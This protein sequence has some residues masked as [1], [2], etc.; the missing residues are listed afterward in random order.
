MKKTI[1]AVFIISVFV[2]FSCTMENS[3]GNDFSFTSIDDRNPVPFNDSV[4][5]IDLAKNMRIGWNL[6]NSLD[7]WTE[8]GLNSELA[9]N[10]TRTTKEIVELGKNKGYTTI[11]IP[12]TWANHIIDDS[13]TIDPKWMARVKEVVDWAY[14][15]GYYVILDEHHSTN[16][17]VQNP[18]PKCSGYMATTDENNIAE[19]K[20][21]LEGIWKQIASTFNNSY[22]ERLIFETIN[23]P[24][25]EFGNGA[26]KWDAVPGS[27]NECRKTF[28]VINEYNQLVLNT[29]RASGGNNAKRFVMVPGNGDKISALLSDVF[30]MPN[31]SAKDKLMVTVHDYTM[32]WSKD[33]ILPSYSNTE[34]NYFETEF[35]KLNDK[36]VAKGIPV[37]LGETGALQGGNLSLEERIKWISD[38]SRITSGYG[39]PLLYW[40]VYADEKWGELD[41]TNLTVRN[42][43]F[44]K[45][46][47][48][49]WKLP[50]ETTPTFV[51][52][53]GNWD[54]W[55]Q[56]SS[57][58]I[59]TNSNG[60]Y[61]LTYSGTDYFGIT[62]KYNN[63]EIIPVSKGDCYK[64]EAD[65]KLTDGN[66]SLSFK[67]MKS[68]DTVIEWNAGK[69][70]VAQNSGFV[71]YETSIKIEGENAK[72]TALLQGMGNSE[73]EVKNIKLSKMRKL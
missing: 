30:R 32:S 72:I 70:D 26:H 4:S 46:M 38:L 11:R 33:L 47:I 51:E 52:V 9:W 36:F 13:Y 12:A 50:S 23:E 49:N 60:V 54:V 1:P 17:G 21:F 42:P 35:K 69:K 64:L 7:C 65:V 66:F 39:M 37:V 45:A 62:F 63:E 31:D 27:C 19:S 71:H 53:T 25:N 29:I 44:V 40:D 43:N 16:G 18:I 68:D 3:S 34:K 55:G 20:R 22:G 6:G 5:A 8:K 61:G 2:S 15:A 14:N 56:T 57:C 24:R 59:S 73:V 48:E 41:R 58:L 10:E 67:T 28:E